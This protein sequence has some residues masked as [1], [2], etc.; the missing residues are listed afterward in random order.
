MPYNCHGRPPGA[1]RPA[2]THD[3]LTPPSLLAA[4]GALRVTPDGYALGRDPFGLDPCASEGQPWPTARTMWTVHEDGAAQDWSPHGEVYLNSPYGSELYLW[5]AR[6][7]DHG[8]GLA[9]LYARTDTQGFASQVWDRA[10]AV[11]FFT[12]RLWFHRPVSGHQC[13]ANC[14]GPMALAI[15][16]ERSVQRVRRLLKPGGDYPGCLVAAAGRKPRRRKAT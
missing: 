14:G 7:A 2:T 15:Y 1:Q 8:D 13:P 9:L 12:R 6:L 11:Y 5:L 3:L 16:G 10:T 4:L